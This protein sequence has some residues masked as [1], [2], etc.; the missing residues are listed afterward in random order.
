MRRWNSSS[1]PSLLEQSVKPFEPRFFFDTLVRLCIPFVD[2]LFQKLFNFSE[3]LQRCVKLVQILQL[4]KYM[5]K[6]NLMIQEV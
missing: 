6:A 5:C 4:P 3:P 2:C 1:N